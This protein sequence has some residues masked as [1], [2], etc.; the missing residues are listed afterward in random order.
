L[1]SARNSSNSDSDL[2]I[3]T[4]SKVITFKSK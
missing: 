2:D 4:E 1:S 3:N